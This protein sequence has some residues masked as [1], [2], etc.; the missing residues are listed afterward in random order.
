MT[1]HQE[2]HRCQ[3]RQGRWGG[4]PVV[5]GA[6]MA[7]ALG[8]GSLG[9][10]AVFMRPLEA[11]FGWSRAEIS[12]AYGHATIGMALGGV[13]WGR[14]SDRVDIRV[15]LAIGGSGMVA[16]LLA[17]AVVQSLWQIY[18]AHL[19]LSGF[20]FA[21]LYAPV[22]SATGAWFDR[23]RGLAIGVVTAGG[24]L[25]QGVL[26]FIANL[27]IDALGWRLAFVSLAAVM[28]V[29]LALSLAPITYPGGSK[30]RAGA[31]T[32]LAGG[33]RNGERARL[34]ML[35]VAALMCCACMGVPLVHLASYVGMVC[36]SPTIG[37]TSLLVAMLFGTVG[38]V[39]FGAIADR[40]GYLP[41][42]ALAS[43]M[44]S[45]CV[46]AYPWLGDSSSLLLLS[47]IFG[48][49]FAGNMTCLVLCVQD[50]VPAQRFGAALGMVMS[51]AWAGMGIG[52]YAGGA[53]FDMY[54]SYTLPFALGSAAG[55]LNLLA[56]SALMLWSKM[57]AA[58]NPDLPSICLAA[59]C[60]PS[61]SPA[62]LQIS[63]LSV[64][65]G[66]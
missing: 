43:A 9:L 57:Q 16:P 19:L 17:M 60:L 41:S 35:A 8:F 51:V 46:G 36:S 62:M 39:L 40:I 63:D 21:V 37:A 64:K 28:L 53:L 15:L 22:L 23:H 7:M 6:S 26:P 58:S 65:A 5:G 3:A 45:I 47:A 59:A 10:V 55:F 42:Y 44:Q 50:A 29:G 27:L 49:G 66:R 13:G 4:I 61:A 48:F 12:L 25:G 38:R 2:P 14:L 54:L 31:A 52:G 32:L 18:L 24:A 11:E 33:E 30:F 20:G 1:P 56:I 34:I